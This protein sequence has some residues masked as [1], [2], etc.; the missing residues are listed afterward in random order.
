M[1]IVSYKLLCYVKLHS[2]YSQYSWFSRVINSSS[3]DTFMTLVRLL[4][5]KGGDIYQPNKNGQTPLSFC[6]NKEV[7]TVIK[8]VIIVFY[9]FH[10]I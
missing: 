2:R 9:T 6:N 3:V 8:Q 4:I 5:E 10:F 1:E 7:G